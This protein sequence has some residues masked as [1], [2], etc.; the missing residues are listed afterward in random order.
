MAPFEEKIYLTVLSEIFL[1]QEE[2][3]EILLRLPLKRTAFSPILKELVF[4]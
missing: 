3:I 2:F 1:R 4:Y